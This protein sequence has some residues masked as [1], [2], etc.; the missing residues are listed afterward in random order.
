MRHSSAAARRAVF[1]QPRRQPISDY[2][3]RF[4]NHDESLAFL[5]TLRCVDDERAIELSTDEQYDGRA[6]ELWQGN[7]RVARFVIRERT[8]KIE[9]DDGRRAAETGGKPAAV[10]PAV[11]GKGRSWTP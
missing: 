6:L 1:A 9:L 5:K 11:Q 7:R 4:Y 10:R 3:L 8:A 2:R